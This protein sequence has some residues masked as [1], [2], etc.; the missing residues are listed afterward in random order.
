MVDRRFIEEY[1]PLEEVSRES[2]K[3]KSIRHGHISTLHLWWA[4]RPLAA[5]R[6]TIYASLI[7]VPENDRK[8]KDCKDHIVDLSKWKNSLNKTVI[9]KAR[10]HI[11]DYNK[12]T[13]RILDPFSGGGLSHWN[14]YGW[15][16]RRMHPTIILSQA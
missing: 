9:N 16:V 8:I 5:S 3:E 7:P 4:R 6:T 2:S 11:L 15:A 13:P 10:K 1:F 12:R 14:H